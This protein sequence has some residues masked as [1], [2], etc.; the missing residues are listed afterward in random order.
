MTEIR[1]VLL[2]GFMG[3]GKSTVGP[4]LA[5]ALGWRFVDFDDAVEAREGA[6]IPE[7][8]RTRG[9]AYF[10][11]AEARVAAELL[12]E[13]DV[14][15]GSGGGWAAVPG[16]LESLPAGTVSVWLKVGAEEAVHRSGGQAG[17]RPLLEGGDPLAKARRLLADRLP[18]YRTAELAVDTQGRSPEDVVQ[19]IVVLLDSHHLNTRT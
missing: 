14:V 1:R 16:R 15:L 9:E 18:A 19:E 17:R 10:R 12:Q 3:S 6:T 2:V 4:L 11:D 7:L 5:D 8:F 13:R